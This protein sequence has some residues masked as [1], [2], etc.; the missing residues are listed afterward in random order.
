M[1]LKV[2]NMAVLNSY[3]SMLLLGILKMGFKIV[4]L[5]LPEFFTALYFIQQYIIS[6]EF[7]NTCKMLLLLWLIPD[8]KIEDKLE[9]EDPSKKEPAKQP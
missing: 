1:Q 6:Y 7:F 3:F 8:K 2:A 5:W 9:T 4:L